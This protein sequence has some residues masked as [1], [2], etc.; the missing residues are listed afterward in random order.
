M[1]ALALTE[2]FKKAIDMGIPERDR[3]I[4]GGRWDW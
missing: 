2:G 1:V 3:M 4:W